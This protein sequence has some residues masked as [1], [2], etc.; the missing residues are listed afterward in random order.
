MVTR[1]MYCQDDA[2]H[3]IY[4]FRI[5]GGMVRSGCAATRVVVRSNSLYCLMNCRK[6]VNV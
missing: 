4:I 6:Y 3:K 2:H 1:R 5:C